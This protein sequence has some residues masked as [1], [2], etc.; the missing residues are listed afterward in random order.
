MLIWAGE[1]CVLIMT[2]RVPVNCCYLD[3]LAVQV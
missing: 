2:D 3:D 1:S